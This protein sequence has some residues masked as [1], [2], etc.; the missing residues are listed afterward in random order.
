MSDHNHHDDEK[1]ILLP[2]P[3]PW[4]VTMAFGLTLIFMGLVTHWSVSVVGFGLTVY[5]IIYWFKDIY[6]HELHE[7]S[8]KL[9]TPEEH[10]PELHPRTVEHLH[11]GEAGHRIHYPERVHPYVA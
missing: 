9:H 4:P 1:H 2:A 8:E 10:E 7:P 3:T 11:L 5:G 6:P